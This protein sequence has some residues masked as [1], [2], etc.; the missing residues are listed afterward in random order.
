MV[1][2][3]VPL[4][5][6]VISDQSPDQS[7]KQSIPEDT[8]DQHLWNVYPHLPNA[9]NPN[10]SST[11]STTSQSVDDNTVDTTTETTE[12]NTVKDK[13]SKRDDNAPLPRKGKSRRQRNSITEVPT[14]NTMPHSKQKAVSSISQQITGPDAL[15]QNEDEPNPSPPKLSSSENGQSKKGNNTETADSEN[16]SKSTESP[17]GNQRHKPLKRNRIPPETEERRKTAQEWQRTFDYINRYCVLRVKQKRKYYD[18]N[19]DGIL[20]P[21]YCG[22]NHPAYL[23][24][25]GMPATLNEYNRQIQSG[26]WTK[27]TYEQSMQELLDSI[28]KIP[29]GFFRKVRILYLWAH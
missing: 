22:V 26:K 16:Q 17:D 6:V 20:R 11:S 18:G 19:I 21:D 4:K 10:T 13:D 25:W 3:C 15:H 12:D 23:L 28:T 9:M 1:L 8:N 5:N 29:S 14:I 2:R 7:P 27:T 24:F